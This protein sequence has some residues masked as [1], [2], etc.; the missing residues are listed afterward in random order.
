MPANRSHLTAKKVNSD[1]LSCFTDGFISAT[2][3][4]DPVLWGHFIL[5]NSPDENFRVNAILI[6]GLSTFPTS[7][8]DISYI[9]GGRGISDVTLAVPYSPGLQYE[10]PK[11]QSNTISFF[12]LW[13]ATRLLRLWTQ[14]SQESVQD[15]KES[16]NPTAELKTENLSEA[17]WLPFDSGFGL[18]ALFLCMIRIHGNRMLGISWKVRPWMKSLHTDGKTYIEASGWC[19]GKQLSYFF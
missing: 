1:K 14:D 10:E 19:R 17:S 5:K 12:C 16:A 18:S 4:Y 13:M 8:H 15:V 7:V 6:H 2:N 3:K 11:W 9:A